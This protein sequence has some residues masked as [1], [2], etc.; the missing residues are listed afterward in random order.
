[1]IQDHIHFKSGVLPVGI[2][3]VFSVVMFS[4]VNSQ[5]SGGMTMGKKDEQQIR[6]VVKHYFEGSYHGDKARLLRAFHPDAHVVGNF[7]SN[8]VDWTR[9]EFITRATTNPTQSGRGEAYSKSILSI[10]SETDAAMVKAKV[11]AGG[12]YFTDYITLLKIDGR[13]VIR[14]KSFTNA[15]SGRDDMEP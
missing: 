12:H 7:D 9:D 4:C 14:H 2:I 10:D 6:D 11:Y 5:E 15:S 13:W 3:I 1:M 8:T